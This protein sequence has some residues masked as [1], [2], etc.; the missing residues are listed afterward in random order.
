MA[1]FFRV[2][3]VGEALA[4]F[5]PTRR[6][7]TERVAL[8][9]AAGRAL[10]ADVVAPEP[11][12]GFA[13]S[14]VDGFAVRAADTFGASESLPAYLELAGAV[15]MGR[16]A[17]KLIE[18]GTAIA[19]PTG[20]ALPEGADAIVMVEHTSPGAPGTIE[21]VRPAAP[22][23]AVVR[24]DED[25][26]VGALALPA[27]RRLGAVEIALVAAL[28]ITDVEVRLRPVVTI[29]STGNE[30]RPPGTP[31]LAVGEVRDA[32]ASGL[33][34]L[35]SDAGGIPSY[36]G[37]VPDDENA[38]EAVLR[39]AL[40]ASDLVAVSAGSSVGARD[41]TSDVVSR[42]GEPGIWCHGLA[43]KPGKPTLLADCGGTPVLG[44][45]GN[46]VSALVVFRLIGAPL[47]RL[48]GG[49]EE[50]AAAPVVRAVLTADVPSAAGRLDV[51]AVR[52][53]D[54]EATPLYGRSSQLSLLARADGLLLVAEE[55]SG[56]YAGA[57]VDVE[58]LR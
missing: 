2:R 14:A 48:L 33:A 50:P 26:A 43:L 20:G 22:G 40:A 41:L 47:V 31:E 42:L 52:L 38:L 9:E 24:A 3:R 37:I 12:P 13:R 18:P 28:G 19:I 15:E 39:R 35:V 5:R 58:L 55:A 34:A 57:E 49:L 56:L 51:V 21:V 8:A 25:L 6:T 54:G 11:L 32:T 30:V 36:A 23:D 4:G 10:A 29:V 16:P 45:P 27:G 44:L 1:E 46:P 53:E 17:P 7:G